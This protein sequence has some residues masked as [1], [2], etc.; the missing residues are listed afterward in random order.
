MNT[1]YVINSIACAVPS[2]KIFHDVS[3]RIHTVVLLCMYFYNTPAVSEPS[4][5]VSKLAA[6]AVKPRFEVLSA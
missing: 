6:F 5:L 3:L 4:V 1:K 2:H